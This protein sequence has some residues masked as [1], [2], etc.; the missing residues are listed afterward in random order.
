MSSSTALRTLARVALTQRRNAFGLN[1]DRMRFIRLLFQP[2]L[3]AAAIWS[4]RERVG[5]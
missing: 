2:V 3:V 5:A 4:T 1:T